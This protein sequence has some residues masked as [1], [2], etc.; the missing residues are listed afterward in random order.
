MK[1]PLRLNTA[2]VRILPEDPSFATMNAGARPGKEAPAE[3]RANGCAQDFIV[4]SLDGAYTATEWST[5]SAGGS[6]EVY[7]PAFIPSPLRMPMACTG[8][9]EVEVGHVRHH[10]WKSHLV[11]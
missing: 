2:E 11:V 9:A 3:N 4:L 10:L 7:E 1:L 8:S 5:G 6:I